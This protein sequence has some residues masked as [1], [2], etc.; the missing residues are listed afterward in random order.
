MVS[1]FPKSAAA[2]AALF[3]LLPVAAQ[4]QD[5]GDPQ[6]FAV[7]GQATMVVQGVGGFD[8]P[9]RGPNSLTPEQVR[10]TID[11]TLYAGVRPWAGGELW[12]NPEIDQGFGLSNTLGVAGFPSAEAYKVGK[13]EPYLRLQ[14]LF[15]R[16]T[17][18]L[19]G[20]AS[21]V[22]PAMNVLGGT[23]AANRLVLTLGKFGIGDVFDTNRY[24]H[25]PRSDFLNW[26]AVDT[27]SFDYAAD[28]WGY[29]TGVATEWYQ[30][31]WTLRAGLFNLSKVP[32]GETL[33]RDFRQYQVDIEV[34]HRHLLGGQPG[35][36]RITAF[37]NR[38][39]FGRFDDALALGAAQGQAADT[40]LVRQRTTRMGA[41]VN[42]EQAVTSTLGLF[43]R[44]GFADGAIEPYDFTDIDR[45]AQLGTSLNGAGW[46]RTNDRI[47]LVG[48]V[49]GISRDHQRYLDAGGLGVLVGDGKLP[50]PGSEA[51]AEAYYD[52]QPRKG[53]DVTFDYQFVANPGYNRD[54]GPANVLALRLHGGF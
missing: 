37:R 27:G 13:D 7:H 53:F 4:A 3:F 19:D 35:A 25:D 20:E 31:A 9:Y 34:E 38:G 39:R 2:A 1:V 32:N 48:I 47:G 14:R 41:D 49:N 24:A 46:G 12:V 54:R 42:V 43:A 45:T 50:H 33:E 5:T 15:F 40:S 29:S 10:E 8:D 21:A 30:G 17:I 52:W 28:A 11:V 26:S 16:Q 23:Q 36:I 51:I 44:A 22:A 18:G 6:A